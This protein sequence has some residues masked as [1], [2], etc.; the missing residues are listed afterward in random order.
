VDTLPIKKNKIAVKPRRLDYL[1]CIENDEIWIKKR[2]EKDIWQG[3]YDFPEGENMDNKKM[4]LLSSSE[5][6]LSHQKLS[7]YFW[8]AEK[9]PQK[10]KLTAQKIKILQ[11][12]E[13]AM[14][15][16]IHNFAIH[17]QLVASS[18]D[19]KRPNVKKL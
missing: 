2:T 17:Y 18:V 5:H 16:P 3:L 8:K 1:V 14:P 13:F 15:K 7:I 6:L 11:F 9:L 12:F 4:I 10:L 19:K